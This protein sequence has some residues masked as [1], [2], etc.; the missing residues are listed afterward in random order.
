MIPS[1]RFLI[2]CLS[3]CTSF[4]PV[5]PKPAALT[6]SPFSLTSTESSPEHFR[7]LPCECGHMKALQ[8]PPLFDDETPAQSKPQRMNTTDLKIHT[9][10]PNQ[11]PYLHKLTNQPTTKETD[12]PSPPRKEIS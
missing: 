7:T 2:I 12:L 3:F 8:L 5:I 10:P 11:C 9:F 6:I 4:R 1:A